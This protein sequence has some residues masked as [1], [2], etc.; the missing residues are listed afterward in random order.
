MR[1]PFCHNAGLLDMEA[2]AEMED[3]ALLRFLESRKGLLDGVAFTGGEPLLRSD[4]P[5]LLEKIR[6]L[7]FSTKIDTNG[8]HPERLKDILGAGLA[9][10]VAMDIKNCPARY[11][12]TTG[13]P[14]FS[15]ERIEES[16]RLLIEGDVPYEFRT[17]VVRQFHDEEAFREIGPWIRGAE[18]YYLQKFTDRESVPFAGLDPVEDAEM[19]V[20]ADIVRPYVNNVEVR[21]VG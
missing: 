15:T 10:Y 21:G 9:D 6:A 19:R 8:N 20:F 2:P 1:C 13:I 4:L 17:T 11:A 5:I 3:E 14:G 12:E 16:I 18:R 7:G